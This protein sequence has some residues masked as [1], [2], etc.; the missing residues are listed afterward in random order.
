MEYLYTKNKNPDLLQPLAERFLQYYQF[1]KANTYLSLLLQGQNDYLAL[2][3]DPRK[4]IYMRLHDSTIGL[5]D[6][7]ALDAVFSLVQSYRSHDM[8]A[9]DDMLFYK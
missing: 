1:D 7:H 2:T 8:L 9:D 5:D 4:V 6:I 3:L